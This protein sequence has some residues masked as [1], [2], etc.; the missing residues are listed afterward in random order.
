MVDIAE[1]TAFLHE[2]IPVTAGLG[3]SVLEFDEQGLV[4]GAPLARNRNHSN[5]AFGG[6]LS[7]V[8]IVS[9]WTLLYLKLKEAGI[10]AHLVIQ[11]SHFDFREPVAEDF[12][13]Q[14][15]MPTDE[16][17]QRFVGMLRRRGRA[18]ISVISR[19]VADGSEG[20]EH[21]GIYAATLQAG[22]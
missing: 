22:D 12:Q 14:A 15:L 10:D 20:G 18:R 3:I 21:E 13:A 8:G 19:I 17:W 6:S 4:I 16:A 5:T 9:G 7:V 2:Q 1:V 11:K